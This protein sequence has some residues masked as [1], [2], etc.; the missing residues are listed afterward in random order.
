MSFDTNT[1]HFV[2][3]GST[4]LQGFHFGGLIDEVQIFNRALGAEEIASIYSACCGGI[5]YARK[6]YLTVT[7]TGTG[8]GA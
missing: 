4:Q 8:T 5:C 1:V 7:K 3:R 6:F 2:S